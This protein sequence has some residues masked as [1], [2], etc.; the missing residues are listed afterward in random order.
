MR[1]ALCQND[2]E[3]QNPHIISE[4]IY[5]PLYDDIHRY[6]VLS[7]LERAPR[8]IEQKGLRED[9]LCQVCETHIS[10]AEDYAKR[11]LFGGAEITIEQKDKFIHIDELDYKYFKIFLLSVLWRAS[12][13]KQDFF[14]QV[15]LGRHEEILREMILKGNP[16]P[17]DK[18]G[19]L[20]FVIMH[21]G[22]VLSDLIMQPTWTRIEGHYCY[23]FVFGG[24]LWVYFISGHNI[25]SDFKK[26]FLSDTGKATFILSTIEKHTKIID[27]AK[28]LKDLG[29]IK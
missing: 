12:I 18:Y 29:R 3:L 9:M 8:P 6:H 27:F 5:E 19:I 21:E 7:I 24:F 25:P 15:W 22:K 10:K 28:E 14:T 13:S 2:R 11:V 26:L 20:A 23:R 16:G 17:S 1:C 4:F